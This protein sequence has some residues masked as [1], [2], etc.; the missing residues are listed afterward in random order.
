MKKYIS[1]V[2]KKSNVSSYGYYAQYVFS[3]LA[4]TCL[5]IVIPLRF[6]GHE[7]KYLQQVLDSFK[8][9]HPNRP[10]IYFAGDSSLDNK[11]WVTQYAE[12]V[13]GYENILGG[14]S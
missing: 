5:S 1:K 7:A 12:A 13:N 14:T 3:I 8:E 9:H 2:E 11:Y 10:N 6:Y 4:F